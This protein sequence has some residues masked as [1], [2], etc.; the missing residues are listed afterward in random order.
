[1]QFSAILTSIFLVGA[2]TASTIAPAYA[3]GRDNSRAD[4]V[5]LDM[6]QAYKQRDRK[7][8]SSLLP[9]VKGTV[10]EPWAAYWDLSARLDEAGTTE[11]QSFMSRFAG[12]YQEDRLRAEWLLQLGRNPMTNTESTTS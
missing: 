11:I 8:L 5:I 7:R 3:Q 2:V 6:A 4:E 12:S 9:Q 10:L 1:M